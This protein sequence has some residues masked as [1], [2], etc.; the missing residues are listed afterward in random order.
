[1]HGTSIL[2][3]ADFSE[4][5]RMWLSGAFTTACCRVDSEEEL[6][7]IHNDAVE[8]GLEVYLITDSGKTGQSA[9]SD[10]S[11]TIRNVQ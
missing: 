8:A 4:V 2:F 7:A 10:S 1:V 3:L 9:C 11:E 5:E 6:M